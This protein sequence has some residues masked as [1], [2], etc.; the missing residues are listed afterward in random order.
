ML[1]MP[2]RGSAQP[3]GLLE[4]AGDARRR[5]ARRRGERVLTLAERRDHVIQFPLVDIVAGARVRLREHAHEVA[6]VVAA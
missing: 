6:G 1:G 5:L 3:Q 4:P 2:E